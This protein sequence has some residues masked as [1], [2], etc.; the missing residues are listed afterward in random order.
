VQVFEWTVDCVF[1]V[2][3]VH[4]FFVAY[5]AKEY[6]AYVVVRREIVRE[7]LRYWFWVD[8]ISCI[9]FETVVAA[10]VAGDVKSEVMAVQLVKFLRLS[11]LV[12]LTRIINV[13]KRLDYVEALAGL[14]PA[15]VSLVLLILQIVAVG[16]VF[17]CLWWGISS[18]LPVRQACTPPTRLCVV[19][20]AYAHTARCTHCSRVNLFFQGKRAW[21]DV[22]SVVVNPLRDAPFGDQYSTSMY[23]A[24]TTLSSTGYGDIV[25]INV[26]ERILAT[27]FF[28]VG[29]GVFGYVTA[30][31]AEVV[32]RMNR[33]D[34]AL[35]T[36]I[37]KITEYLT[38]FG[39][40]G[41]FRK[42]IKDHARTVR[43][44]PSAYSLPHL[45]PSLPSLPLLSPSLSSLPHLS[46]SH[47]PAWKQPRPL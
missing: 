5:Y 36:S 7:Y 46:S 35:M 18:I 15:S 21:F 33:G 44:P 42:S 39:I 27:V 6:D 32:E 8:L 3:L 40:E 45:S 10:A 12:K 43:F 28:L 13:R 14:H 29:G 47:W 34:Q 20:G 16:H 2:D 24:V 11:R 25:P 22:P 9:P 1:F 37:F 19:V 17:A 23:F 30:V 26:N 31:V 4:N 38:Q 41:T